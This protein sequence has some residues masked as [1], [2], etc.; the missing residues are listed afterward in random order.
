MVAWLLWTAWKL[1]AGWQ[2][3]P[4]GLLVTCLGAVGLCLAATGVAV[5]V[6][7]HNRQTTAEN[8]RLTAV[9]TRLRQERDLLRT[10]VDTLPDYIYA[11]DR[12]GR[13]VF[14]NTAH[15]HDFGAASPAAMKGR[16]DFDFFPR[17]LA[18]QFLADE[19]NILA[20]GKSVI[21]QEQFQ[22]RPNAPEGGKI[23][24]LSSKVIWRG[25]NGEILG[26]VGVTRDIHE[27]KRTQDALRQTEHRLLEVL[28]RTRCILNSGLVEGMAGW[29]ERALDDNSPF[30]W[31][32]PVQNLE[33]AQEVCPLE[34]P[35]G[36]SYQQI[37]TASRHPEDSRA[38][39]QQAGN[40]LL[41]D[42][43]FFRNEFRCTDRHGMEHWM[44]QFVTVENFRD[45]DR[46]HG[47]EAQRA[48]VAQQRGEV[49]PVHR[50]IGAKQPRIA[51]L[52]VC[53]FARLA[54]TTTQNR[55][56]QRAAEGEMRGHP[57]RRA[58]R[59]SG[60]DA[61]GCRAHADAHQ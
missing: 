59:L 55:G 17:A 7:W 15:A 33:G 5:G 32:F 41:Q 60:A 53:G 11:K 29:R 20:T 19:Q 36:K 56:V 39:S 10:I 2:N 26:T 24:T 6:F 1:S 46:H 54:G 35:P 27:I 25:R 43:P 47:A 4:P 31:N 61:T 42:L 57:G 14:N 23:W 12:E 44:L 13:F 52:R 37:W 50:A 18:E 34:L 30:R 45:H 9:S 48:G 21:N 16:S 58:A 28:R 22:A 51:G 40:A 38:M 49:A 3:A 8:A